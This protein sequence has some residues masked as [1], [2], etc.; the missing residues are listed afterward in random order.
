MKVFVTGGTGFIGAEILSELVRAEHEVTA[1]VRDPARLLVRGLK[2]GSGNVLD[3]ASYEPAL[4]GSDACVHLVGILREFPDQG[5]TFE[6]LN[7]QATVNLLRSC[8]KLGVRRFLHMSANGAERAISTR[9]MITK[10]K[11]EEAVRASS[12]DYTIF[13]PGLVFG[14]SVDRPN[15]VGMLEEAMSKLPAMAYFGSG[16]YRLAPVSA[17]DVARSFARALND[18]AASGKAFHLCGPESYSYLELLKM[19]REARAYRCKLFP[20]PVWLG[21]ATAG[22]LG[23]YPWF[24]LTAG[25]LRMLLEGNLCPAGA[26]SPRDLGVEPES[27]RSWLLARTGG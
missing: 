19:L 13:R 6:K 9:Y 23:R 26:P 14:G 5:I 7:Y 15:F 10:A 27:F 16:D 25:M 12:L 1:L 3:P 17:R 21:R 8:G 24:P 20:L 11:A 18:P 4:K 22:V 2:H